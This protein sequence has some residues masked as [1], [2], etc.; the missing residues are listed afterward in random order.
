M[1]NLD[2]LERGED[3]QEV[4]EQLL[5]VPL[6]HMRVQLQ[7]PEVEHGGRRQTSANPFTVA[8]TEEPGATDRGARSIEAQVSPGRDRNPDGSSPVSL[9]QPRAPNLQQLANENRYVLCLGSKGTGKS[10]Y[11][12]QAFRARIA[13]GGRGV[14]FDPIGNRG[15]LGYV[16]HSGAEFWAAWKRFSAAAAAAPAGRRGFG[17]VIQPGWEGLESLG[18][19]WRMIFELGDVLLV[20][21][22]APMIAPVDGSADPALKHLVRLGRNRR[23]DIITTCHVPAQLD[24]GLRG[25]RDVV[26]TF[27]QVE[28]DYADQ[29]AA[30]FPGLGPAGPQLIASLPTFHYLRV[31]NGRVTRG[32]VRL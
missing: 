17:L 7:D 13:A 25:I 1:F 4:G 3:L 27:R 6:E 31:E 19:V 23:I 22:E 30:M 32:V 28:A 11:A 12:E 21:D 16:V 5:E 15:H 8:M 10:T 20:L 26:V 18:G 24:K 2:S 29:V 14:W 9:A